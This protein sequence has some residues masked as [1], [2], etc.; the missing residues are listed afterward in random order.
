MVETEDGRAQ[1]PDDMASSGGVRQLK[2]A[3]RKQMAEALQRLTVEDTARQSSAVTEQILRQPWFESAHN[4]SVYVSMA[5]G[6]VQTKE[7]CRS[8]LD[9]GKHLYVPR[10]AASPAVTSS[11]T[12]KFDSDMRMLRIR[13][14]QDYEA[15]VMNRWGI[16]EPDDLYQNEQRLD[17]GLEPCAG[18]TSGLC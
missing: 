14:W 11:A 18:R 4:V 10:F 16:R 6:E 1:G 5:K 7:I 12:T 13:D 15:M 17:G 8:V 2:R 9:R 3:M